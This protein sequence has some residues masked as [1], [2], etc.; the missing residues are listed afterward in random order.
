VL[1]RKLSGLHRLARLYEIAIQGATKCYTRCYICERP[2]INYGVQ[3]RFGLSRRPLLDLKSQYSVF[4][5][6]EECPSRKLMFAP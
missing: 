3:T 1:P 5:N 4:L 6:R 2:W